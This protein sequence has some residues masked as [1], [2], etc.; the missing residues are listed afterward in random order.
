M[1][2]FL[3]YLAVLLVFSGLFM[4]GYYAGAMV[5]QAAAAAAY[6]AGVDDT[7]V[8]LV[9]NLEKASTDPDFDPDV[10]YIYLRNAID[11][12]VQNGEMDLQN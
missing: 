4:L 12:G 8:V 3:M 9:D 6:E 7:V 2:D 11:K 10:T 5:A 1:I